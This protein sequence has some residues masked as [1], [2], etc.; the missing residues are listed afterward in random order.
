MMFWLQT[1]VADD[2]YSSQNMHYTICISKKIGFPEVFLSMTFN[3]QWFEIIDAVVPNQSGTDRQN[4]ATHVFW[5]KL[6]A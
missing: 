4:L 6:F 1:Y 3:R 5:I 2:P